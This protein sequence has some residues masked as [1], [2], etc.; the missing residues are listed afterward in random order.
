MNF[1]FSYHATLQCPSVNFH[2]VANRFPKF[3]SHSN[4]LKSQIIIFIKIHTIAWGWHPVI[5]NSYLLCFRI[6]NILFAPSRATDASKNRE[7][8]RHEEKRELMEATR[9]TQ[10]RFSSETLITT[11]TLVSAALKS[12]NKREED[13]TFQLL[14]IH[15]YRR[16]VNT[17]QKKEKLNAFLI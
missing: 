14:R 10:H 12:V 13:K 4:L 15:A 3:P 17:E 11:S 9:R 7:N 5:D 8:M 6:E 1:F 16:L 2:P